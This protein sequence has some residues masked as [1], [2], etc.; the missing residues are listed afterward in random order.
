M[1]IVTL[2]H[3]KGVLF[4]VNLKKIITANSLVLVLFGIL[5]NPFQLNYSNNQSPL[6][7]FA[8]DSNK[9]IYAYLKGDWDGGDNM[10]IYY[11]GGSSSNTF[12]TAA[13]MTKV[14]SN[15]WEGL[16]IYDVP[17]DTTNF[18]VRDR[19]GS[20]AGDKNQSVDIS[21]SSLFISGSPNNYKA[22]EVGAWV[23]DNTKRTATFVDN[24]GLS[25][26]DV[27]LLLNKINT[28]STSTSFGF[29]AYPQIDDLFFTTNTF[30]GSTTVD[31]DFGE[32]TTID[33]KKQR[34]LENYNRGSAV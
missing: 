22:L 1:N 34:L 12:E 19:S 21:I 13:Q 14:I 23:S 26:N 30:T 20:W 27:V 24:L 33:N 6:N 29:N 7:T 4:F 16:Y 31:D 2:N 8:S 32:S 15:Y 3:K 11:W 25:N 18:L 9:R 5:I 28:C 10:Y 17:N